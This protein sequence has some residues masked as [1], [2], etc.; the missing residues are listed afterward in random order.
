MRA[1]FCLCPT[2]DSKGFTARL[3]FSIVHACIPIWI[4][5]FDR[6]LRWNEILFPY[7]HIIDWRRVVVIASI[8]DV[9]SGKL[10]SKLITMRKSG[11]ADY[12]IRYIRTISH[13]LLFDYTYGSAPD[14]ADTAIRELEYRL[15]L[16]T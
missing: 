7:P 3:Y 15:K 10:L 16:K 11:V 6:A 5:G 4:D 13:H 8:Q 2:G 14:A 9:V 1:S 12:Y